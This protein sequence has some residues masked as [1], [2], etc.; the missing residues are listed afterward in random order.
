MVFITQSNENSKKLFINRDW[1]VT[2][3]YPHKFNCLMPIQTPL[4]AVGLCRLELMEFQSPYV[5]RHLMKNNNGSYNSNFVLLDDG[6]DIAEYELNGDWLE[7]YEMMAFIDSA[8]ILSL[9]EDFNLLLADVIEL[10]KRIFNTDGTPSTSSIFEDD[11]NSNLVGG[12]FFLECT[13]TSGTVT[14]GGHWLKLLGL[15]GRGDITLSAGEQLDVN[16]SYDVLNLINVHTNFGRSVY[17]GD[18]KAGGLVPSNIFWTVPNVDFSGYTTLYQKMNSTGM[19]AFHLPVLEDIYI[20]FTDKYGDSVDLAFYTLLLTFDVTE[21]TPAPE[22][23][24][25]YRAR[26]KMM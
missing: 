11:F 17:S 12:P 24:T 6:S 22:P 16:I 8:I 20:H 19:T 18:T 10:K 26:Q 13:A 4:N 3:N 15:Y 5:V 14:I 9:W 7:K 21:K 2:E 1:K 23:E 25:I